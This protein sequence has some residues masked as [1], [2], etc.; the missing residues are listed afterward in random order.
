MKIFKPKIIEEI[1]EEEDKKSDE[2]KKLEED[3]AKL[4][5]KQGLVGEQLLQTWKDS[6]VESYK[7]RQKQKEIEMEEEKKMRTSAMSVQSKNIKR[8]LRQIFTSR[9]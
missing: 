8:S 3:L 7:Y 1:E 4:D 2:L 5:K 6:I 9:V